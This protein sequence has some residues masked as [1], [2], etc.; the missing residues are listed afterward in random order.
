MSGA[1]VELVHRCS[2]LPQGQG[3]QLV[4]IAGAPTSGKSILA[5]QSAPTLNAGGR[6]V[7]VSHMNGFHPDH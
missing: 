4:A 6:P 7:R 2:L 1:P 3:R 5:P